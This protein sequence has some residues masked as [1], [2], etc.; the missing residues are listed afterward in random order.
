VAGRRG[1]GS[2]RRTI[3]PWRPGRRGWNNI[4]EEASPLLP[5]AKGGPST[6]HSDRN[7]PCLPRQR[8]IILTT[9]GRFF[10]DGMTI[11]VAPLW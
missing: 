9:D 7:V 10:Q 4:A 8:P 3:P 5:V 1:G 6:K 2:R 11:P